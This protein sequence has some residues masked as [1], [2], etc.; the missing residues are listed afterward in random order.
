MAIVLASASPRRKELM[1]LITQNFEV[2]P[3][4]VKEDGVKG[5]TP[6]RLAQKLSEL[7]CRAGALRRPYD[8]VI[9]CDTVVEY[10]ERVFGKPANEED[11]RVMLSTLQGHTHKVHTGV[12]VFYDGSETEF[13]CTTYVS[14]LPMS[15]E[16]IDA[17]IA[18]GEPMDKAGAY[19]IQGAASKFIDGVQGDYFN[20]VGL[21]VSRLYHLLQGLGVLETTAAAVPQTEAEA[22]TTEPTAPQADTVP[23]GGE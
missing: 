11:A 19:G 3:L 2:L 17:Y 15:N 1:G 23:A 22:E 18:T 14:F 16:E 21:P 6:A 8:V 12:C 7:K 5:S 10:N 20:V 9:G 4:A 13:V